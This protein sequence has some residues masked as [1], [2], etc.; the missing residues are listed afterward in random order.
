EHRLNGK[1]NDD[2]IRRVADQVS[3]KGREL[4]AQIDKARKEAAAKP[5]VAAA[6][7][8]AP[9]DSHAEL[10][11]AYR[12]FATGD[13]DTAESLLTKILGSKPEAQAYALRGCARYTRAMLSRKAD[14]M[15]ASAAEDF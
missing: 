13:F 14:A 1:P 4:T 9:R 11:L 8:P 5:Q 7:P 2:E 3:I 6:A 15:L 12:A 10:E